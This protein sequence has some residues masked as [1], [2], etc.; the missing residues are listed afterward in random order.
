MRYRS[1]NEKSRVVRYGGLLTKDIDLFVDPPVFCPFS[2]SFCRKKPCVCEM[3]FERQDMVVC[4][5]R[6]EELGI[7]FNDVSKEIAL[8]GVPYQKKAEVRLSGSFFD[9][10]LCFDK[11]LGANAFAFLEI[12][13]LDLSGSIAGE[14]SKLFSDK[15][16]Q[17]KR[18]PV[19]PNWQMSLKTL[20]MELLKKN[21]ISKE[22]GIPLF[23]AVQDGLWNFIQEKYVVQEGMGITFLIYDFPL[24]NPMRLVSKHSITGDSLV[25]LIQ[26]ESLEPCDKMRLKLSRLFEEAT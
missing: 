18:K 5:K 19:G 16:I 22:L 25:S 26:S 24:D 4:P 1:T 13:S 23:V 8:E 17:S 21:R 11:P 7:I 9:F 15:A 3:A 10:V 2:G 20:F 14:V 6:F 12:Q